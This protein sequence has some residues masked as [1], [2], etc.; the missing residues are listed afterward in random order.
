MSVHRNRAFYAHRL[1]I[2]SAILEKRFVGERLSILDA[3][4]GKGW[5]THELSQ[6][7]HAVVGIDSSETAIKICREN[8]QGEFVQSELDAYGARKG[9]DVV[10]AMDV[11]F[12]VLDDAGWKAS[13]RNLCSLC[14]AY[15]VLLFTDDLRLDRYTLGNYI[16]HRS[17]AEYEAALADCGMSISEEVA[18]D[19]GA[20]PN[21]FYV[22]ERLA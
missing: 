8:R 14:G 7:G 18:Y 22:A 10:I 12:H 13:L 4:C 6:F 11:L 5:L 20:N 21:S 2:V 19:F 16:V 15:G 3:G 17:R 1:G 9:F